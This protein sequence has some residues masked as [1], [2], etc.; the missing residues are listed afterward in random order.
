LAPV[1]QAL[2]ILQQDPPANGSD[3]S[4]KGPT[5]RTTVHYNHAIFCG[6]TAAPVCIQARPPL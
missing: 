2:W 4:V 6:V 3:F 1:P 5:A